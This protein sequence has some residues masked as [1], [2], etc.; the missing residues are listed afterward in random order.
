MTFEDVLIFSHLPIEIF[1]VRVFAMHFWGEIIDLGKNVLS[2]ST[3]SP[4]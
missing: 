3:L 2:L 4:K 1:P